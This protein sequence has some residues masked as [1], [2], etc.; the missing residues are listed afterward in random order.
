METSTFLFEALI[1]TLPVPLQLTLQLIAVAMR[2]PT[3]QR[4]WPTE[5]KFKAA[6]FI[7]SKLPEV[8]QYLLE[9]FEPAWQQAKTEV[10]CI[11]TNPVDV[12][13]QDLE[14]V[15]LPQLAKLF[16]QDKDQVVSGRSFTGTVLQRWGLDS[17]VETTRPLN[18]LLK[19]ANDTDDVVVISCY[20]KDKR[21]VKS[22]AYTFL[23]SL[24]TGARIILSQFALI[25]GKPE[26]L[27]TAFFQVQ[28]G[29]E[30]NAT[31]S[32]L[33]MAAE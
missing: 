32:M 17:A 23:E 29:F 13:N 21:G 4:K 1:L 14:K 2:S 27:K 12:N 19:E 11:S 3:G 10:A 33:T 18:I 8:A 7:L 26:Y 28:H 24:P 16:E 15:T 30:I 25:A 31:G 6:H 5:A 20:Q 9:V 22:A